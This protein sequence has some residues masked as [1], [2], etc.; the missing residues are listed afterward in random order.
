MAL[1]DNV[2]GPA[3]GYDKLW[4]SAFPVLKI[5]NHLRKRSIEKIYGK[6]KESKSGDKL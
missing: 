4:E 2:Y 3:S 6:E 1:Y 5:K